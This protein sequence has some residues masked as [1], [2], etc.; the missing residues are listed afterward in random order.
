H[1]E[2][3]LRLWAPRARAAALRV[4]GETAEATFLIELGSVQQ[5]AGRYLPAME[6][7]GRALELRTRVTGADSLATAE[8]HRRLASA[9]A[10]MGK[11]V[12]AREHSARALAIQ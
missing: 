8:A 9:S 3:A 4:G 10:D 12:Q 11:I 5:K 7:F 2:E 6:T 1:A